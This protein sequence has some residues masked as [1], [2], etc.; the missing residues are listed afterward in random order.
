[1]KNSIGVIKKVF[2]T[3]III[4]IYDLNQLNQ[5]YKGDIYKCNGIDDYILIHKSR[6]EKYLYQITGLYEDEKPIINNDSSKFISIAYFEA[7]PVGSIVNNRFEYGLS[8]YP[9]FGSEVFMISEDIYN[10]IFGKYNN[11][12]IDLGF[13]TNRVDIH[14]P[15]DIDSLFSSHISILG[16]TGSGKSTTVRKLI[17]EVDKLIKKDRISKE[18]VN[19]FIFDVHNEYTNLGDNSKTIEIDE[20][21]IPTE[22]LSLDDWLNLIIPS[23]LVQLP[24]V[25]SALRIG[26]LIEQ[27][28]FGINSEK[29][30]YA[31]CALSLYKGQQTDAVAKRSKVMGFVEKINN[32]A[33]N[34]ASKSYS[35]QFGSFPNGTEKGF[36]NTIESFLSANNFIELTHSYFSNKLETCK[37]SVNS[38]K[39]LQN[40]IE[41]ALCLEESKG[42]NQIRSHCSTLQTRIQN[43]IT[44]YGGNLFSK[45][46]KKIENFKSYFKYKEASFLIFNCNSLENDDLNFLASFILNKAYFESKKNIGER[47]LYNFIFD[48]A[49]KYI[50]ESSSIDAYNS[51]KTFEKIAREGRKFGIFM[52]IASQRAAEL[53]K[54]VLSQC[55]NFILHR[56]RNNI[57]LEQIRKSIPY[58]SDS[59]IYRLSFLKTGNALVVGEAFKIPLE[60]LI[61][62][63][64][65][66]SSSTILSS[67]AWKK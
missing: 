3:K 66:Q 43:L 56:V 55:N 31:F 29:V 51:I 64:K 63:E 34:E 5:N 60:L 16:N 13:L 10:V 42:N 11:L 36:I 33:I 67:N 38:L 44:T 48:E 7:A 26:N 65:G 53:S 39:E 24:I 49:H 12:S 41:I 27:N 59:Q 6:D 32:D 25:L 30:I 47:P 46:T 1:M 4:E 18:K 40:Y 19:F 15:I 2:P 22:E 28:I 52:T 14:P 17:C 45:D 54:T 21:S 23:A 57:D 61:E 35:C 8:S 58:I 50:T 9:L 62:Q 20:I 37:N